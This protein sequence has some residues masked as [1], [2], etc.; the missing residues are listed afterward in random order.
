MIKDRLMIRTF[1]KT[2]EKVREGGMCIPVAINSKC[3]CSKEG[4]V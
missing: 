2:Y 3:K 1:E 4:K